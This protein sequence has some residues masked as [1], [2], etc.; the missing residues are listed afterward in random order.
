MVTVPA[1]GVASRFNRD[2]EQIRDDR[3]ERTLD[4]QSLERKERRYVDRGTMVSEVT[5]TSPLVDDVEAPEG[6]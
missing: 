4:Q 5:G 3:K 2:W 6:P 1:E